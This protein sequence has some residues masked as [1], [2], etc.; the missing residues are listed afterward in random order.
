[1][2]QSIRSVD[3]RRVRPLF[4]LIVPV[5]NVEDYL[6]E[7]LD[8][9]FSQS[10]RDFEIICVNDGSTDSSAVLLK[11]YASKHRQMKVVTQENRGLSAARNS[12]IDVAEGRYACFLDSDDYL[13]FDALSAAAAV[14]EQTSPDILVMG[15]MS[16][17]PGYWD[18]ILSTRDVEYKGNTLEALLNENG[19]RPLIAGKFY[20]L[21]LINDNGI[22][23]NEKVRFGED[24]VFQFSIYPK[25]QHVVFRSHKVYCYRQRPGSLTSRMSISHYEKMN[26][27][28][29]I[30]REILDRLIM[31]G[32]LDGNRPQIAQWFVDFI[33]KDLLSLPNRQAAEAAKTFAEFMDEFFP[34]V[35]LSDSDSTFVEAVK[36]A[37]LDATDPEVSIIVPVHNAEDY[38]LNSY[39]S[40]RW[41]SMRKF[42][43]IYVDDGSTDNS[44]K[45]L[46]GIARDDDRVTVISQ[47]HENA[48]AARNRGMDLARGEYLLFFDA[49]DWVFPEMLSKL[50]EKAKAGNSDVCVC[51]AHGFDIDKQEEIDLPWTCNASMLSDA[52]EFSRETDADHLFC[53]TS[54]APWNKLFR[55]E[56]V[57][58]K[59]LMFQSLP[60]SNDLTF[61]LSALSCAGKISIVDE[62][63]MCYRMNSSS[64]LQG[65][66]KH[67]PDAFFSA[68][69][70]LK[71]FLVNEGLFDSLERPFVAFALDCCLYNLKSLSRS[72]DALEAFEQVFR[73]IQSRALDE[74]GIRGKKEDFFYGYAEDNYS[75]LQDVERSS[76][77]LE[78]VGRRRLF[79]FGEVNRLNLEID[80][81]NE[82]LRNA[83]AHEQSLAQE[84]EEYRNSYSY[85]VGSAMLSIPRM[86]RSVMKTRK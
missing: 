58:G 22:R 76:S 86:L 29:T 18:S 2:K 50:L 35:E 37:H 57:E 63:L 44:L 77:I 33:A 8:S 80:R 5:Y 55:R 21:D 20:L 36:N 6:A 64:S 46:E 42:E 19:A 38:L 43:V 71:S 45:I 26:A 62:A 24:H 25:A 68:L 66:K 67:H 74:L 15:G 7:C 83:R 39:E 85:R 60:N 70:A 40:F 54:P 49:D 75:W 9:V 59:G 52:S 31:D 27:H 30:C 28:F 17:P 32:E 4:S 47:S 65:T 51:R 48:G 10:F 13:T 34:D 79:S 56:F 41:Q 14:I 84:V 12:G 3:G 11:E 61:T 82:D 81:L 1:M 23:F 72:P 16:V 53:F 69:C 73:L 78:F